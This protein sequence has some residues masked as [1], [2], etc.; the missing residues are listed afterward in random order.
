MRTLKALI[1]CYI[2]TQL[3]FDAGDFSLAYLVN[4]GLEVRKQAGLG[5]ITIAYGFE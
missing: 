1:V 3:A 4:M 5:K 2:L